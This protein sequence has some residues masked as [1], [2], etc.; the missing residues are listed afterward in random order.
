MVPGQKESM[1]L[2]KGWL[3][4]HDASVRPALEQVEIQKPWKGTI[5]T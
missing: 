4:T 5:C 1:I 2:G 3:A